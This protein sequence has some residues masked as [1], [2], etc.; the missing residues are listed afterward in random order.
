[1]ERTGRNE[2]RETLRGHL[3]RDSSWAGAGRW[4]TGFT[5]RR[6]TNLHFGSPSSDVR[7]PSH[8]AITLL[9]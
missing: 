8:S 2:P 4:R 7:V 1:M 3:R 9:T 5:L 6:T